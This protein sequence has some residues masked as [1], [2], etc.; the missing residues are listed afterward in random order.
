MRNCGG[1]YGREDGEWGGG[2]PK[3]VSA[4]KPIVT[5]QLKGFPQYG[6]FDGVAGMMVAGVYNVAL[7]G[8]RAR[9]QA[10]P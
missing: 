7:G 4:V 8:K 1:G 9:Y 10:A 6:V 2:E 3:G 5:I